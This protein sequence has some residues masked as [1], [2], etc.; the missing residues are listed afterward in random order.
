MIEAI[1]VWFSQV[2]AAVFEAAVL[3]LL[4]L[5]GLRNFME[6]AFDFTEWFLVG[7]IEMAFLAAVI[8]PLERWRPADRRAVQGP[9]DRARVDIAYTLLHR[10]GG[11]AILVFA[12]MQPLVLD[13]KDGLRDWDDPEWQVYMGQTYVAD[14]PDETL[15]LSVPNKYGYRRSLVPE[16]QRGDGALVAS[17]ERDD[18]VQPEDAT[19]WVKHR[20]EAG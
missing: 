18:L 6:D 10:L 12:V 8:L 7:L 17:D 3:P 19:W 9:G 14:I 2:H 16:F 20:E 1:T 13:L 11:F 5:L 15:K 4:G